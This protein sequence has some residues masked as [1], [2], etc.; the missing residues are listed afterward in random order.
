M[1]ESAVHVTLLRMPL[2]E[3]GRESDANT[4]HGH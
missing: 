3:S 1:S 2:H 4:M